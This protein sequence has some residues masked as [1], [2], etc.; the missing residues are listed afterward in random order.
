MKCFAKILALLTVVLLGA[1]LLFISVEHFRG[2]WALRSRLKELEAKGEKLN[3]AD[4]LPPKVAPEQ[5]A[6]LDLFAL[7]NTLKPFFHMELDAPS[8]MHFV[9]QG[10]ALVSWQRDSW[11]DDKK[12]NTWTQFGEEIRA[13]EPDLDKLQILYSKTG[14]DD[15]FDYS[16]GFV[17]FQIPPLLIFSKETSIVLA[18][19][20]AYD[21]G[22]GDLDAALA[23]QR[24]LLDLVKVIEGQ[25]MMFSQLVRIACAEIA[26]SATWEALQAPDWKDS[27][28]SQMQTA[29]EQ[30]EFPAAM[31]RSFEMERSLEID[32]YRQIRG[33]HAVALKQIA[34]SEMMDNTMAG[35]NYTGLPTHGFILHNVHLPLWQLAW[36]AQ[37]ELRALDRWWP[38]IQGGRVAI[39]NSW[40]E[41]KK[42]NPEFK[43]NAE[44][45]IPLSINP[46]EHLGL[47]DRFRFLFSEEPFSVNGVAILKCLKIETEKNMALTVI[48]LKRYQLRHGKPASQLSALVPEFLPSVPIDRMDGKPLRYRLNPD[49]SFTLYSVGTNGTDEGGDP[50]LE[51]PKGK[52]RGIWYGKDAVWPTAVPDDDSNA[53]AETR[54]QISIQFRPLEKKFAKS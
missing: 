50:Q 26:F 4:W 15:G 3:I 32:T 47:Y 16:K 36:G 31:E 38:I 2:E 21:V 46:D 44:S 7:T 19:A 45:Y 53:Y 33:S 29:W 23:K 34:E 37:D 52:G 40:L 25:P 24:S 42:L 54:H 48:A 39:S 51:D 11:S 28:L 14:F 18:D 17:D 8:R 9:S 30:N 13:A 1:I 20:M 27:Q 6:A 10:R 22:R 43:P 5:N 12:T 41:A 35:D 49:G